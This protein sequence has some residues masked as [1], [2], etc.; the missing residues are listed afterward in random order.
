VCAIL[1]C[2]IDNRRGICD[3]NDL[4]QEDEEAI[5]SLEKKGYLRNDV[6]CIVI[7]EEFKKYLE[8]ECRVTENQ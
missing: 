1:Q 5:L 3:I 4:S 7:K 8:K 6:N 2:A